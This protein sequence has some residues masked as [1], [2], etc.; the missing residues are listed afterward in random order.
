MI[1]LWY[2]TC[3]YTRDYTHCSILVGGSA[4]EQYLTLCN[5]FSLRIGWA[6]CWSLLIVAVVTVFRIH[7]FNL[8]IG[9]P[10]AIFMNL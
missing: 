2:S 8:C 5:N 7:P 10:T 4:C 3:T 1:L 9:H 6:Y